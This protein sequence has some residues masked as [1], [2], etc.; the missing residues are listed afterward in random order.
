[1]AWDGG[2]GRTAFAGS[3]CEQRKLALSAAKG[4]PHGWANHRTADT[5]IFSLGRKFEKSIL[6]Q[7]L[8]ALADFFCVSSLISQR[9]SLRHTS[10]GEFVRPLS[11]LTERTQHKN[12]RWEA[13]TALDIGHES[14]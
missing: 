2:Q 14:L 11:A 12:H 4:E 5:G 8:A 9:S 1:M 13:D 3:E 7:P 6:N 10:I